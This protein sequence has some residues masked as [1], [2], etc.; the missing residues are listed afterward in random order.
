MSP[1]KTRH[2]ILIAIALLV[3]LIL[4]ASVLYLFLPRGYRRTT[5]T[6]TPGP[7]GE[8][9]ILIIGKD[10]R[11]INPALD[12]GGI[13]RIPREKT[14]HSDVIVICHINLNS[15]RLNLVA[16]P[17]DLLVIVPGV[18]AAQSSTDFN[19]MEKITHT[20]ALGGEPLLRRTLEN[21]LGIKIHRF[22][23]F[24]FDTFRMVFRRLRSLLG[25]LRVGKTRL[26]DPDRALKFVRQR[27][28]LTYDDLDRCRNT[29][30]FL[31]TI[32]RATWRFSNTRLGE[33]L[34][35]QVFHIIGDDTDL[36]PAEVSH[37]INE[38]HARGFTPAAVKLAVLVSEGRPV[39]L[40]RYAMTLSCY[41]PIYPEMEKQIE[42]FLKDNEQVRAMDFMTQ[43]PYSWPAYMTLD[44]DLLPSPV[45]DTLQ[46]QRIIER[47]LKTQL[48]P[49]E[50]N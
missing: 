26:D 14:A 5:T 48:A 18:T 10:A 40:D 47:I 3:I 43:Q 22:I 9:N 35:N 7:G 24:D 8:V 33:I 19:R 6:L 37:L 17:R 50:S 30:N 32:L 36:T 38:L 31:H 34:I 15:G 29:L 41:L 2:R 20:Y 46:R 44:Y 1:L 13:S 16:V 39:T 25:P 28:G 49:Q 27:Y 45:D 42:F 12:R 21:L 11:A 23:A 4:T